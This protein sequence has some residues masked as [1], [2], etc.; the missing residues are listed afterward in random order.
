MVIKINAKGIKLT[1]GM[2]NAIKNRLDVIEKFLK[3]SDIMR[4]TVFNVKKDIYVNIMVVYDK[5]IVKVERKGEDFYCILS[6][7]AD[8]LK[9]KLENLHTKKIKRQK[10][11]DKA[12][13][14]FEY[15]DQTA[16]S[17]FMNRE[18]ISKRKKIVLDV[19]TE[20]E[21]VDKMEKL[22]HES[23]IFINADTG[24]YCM[25]YIRNDGDYGLLETE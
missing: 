2:E 10:D 5:K 24:K 17:E 21:A 18:I 16:D 4:V 6:S 11:Q 7:V 14:T 22:G 3:P 12:L 23:F 8:V 13:R 20:G 19:M 1:D 9:D 15:D 25:I